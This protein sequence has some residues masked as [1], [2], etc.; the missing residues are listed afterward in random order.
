MAEVTK[1][2]IQEVHRRIDDMVGEQNQTNICL[3]R[4]DTTLK[5]MP[6]LPDRP[7]E[8]LV[9]LKSGLNGHIADHKDNKRIW[10]RPI[11]GT[12]VDLVKMAVVALVTWLCLRKE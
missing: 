11:I 2:D 10:Q 6:K 8:Q 1:A 4:I 12:V 9:S 3:A 7:C 5:L